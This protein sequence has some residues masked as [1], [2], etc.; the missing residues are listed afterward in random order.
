MFACIFTTWS[1]RPR[2]AAHHRVKSYNNVVYVWT[3]QEPD[4]NGVV[5]SDFLHFMQAIV[6][7]TTVA[8]AALATVVLNKSQCG[9]QLRTPHD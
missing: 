2:T 1:L 9:K 6:L 8:L 7:G 5:E 4:R 3:P